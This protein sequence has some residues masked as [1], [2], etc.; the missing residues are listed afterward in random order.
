MG[1]GMSSD[2]MYNQ[3]SYVRQNL[4]AQK[5]RMSN[6]KNYNGSNRY[7]DEQIKMKLRQEYNS[8]GCSMKHHI[9]KDTYIPYSHWNSNK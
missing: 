3:E 5:N 4:T 2:R 6:F 1:C 8:G 9:N 7:S